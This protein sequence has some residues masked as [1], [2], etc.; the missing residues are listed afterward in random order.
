MRH[1]T[2]KLILM[3]LFIYFV[4]LAYNSF[5]ME[6]VLKCT[7]CYILLTLISSCPSA[8][9]DQIETETACYLLSVVY[10]LAYILINF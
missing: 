4:L 8:F 10:C 6:R 9:L 7:V 2:K 1:D 3:I 5:F